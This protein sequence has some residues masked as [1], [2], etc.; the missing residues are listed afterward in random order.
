[1]LMSLF[2]SLQSIADLL[3]QAADCLEALVTITSNEPSKLSAND[4]QKKFIEERAQDWFANLHDVQMGL[5]SA[6]KNL[7]KAQVSPILHDASSKFS[8]QSTFFMG[9][10]SASRGHSLS[11]LAQDDSVKNGNLSPG[12]MKAFVDVGPKGPEISSTPSSSS[13]SLQNEAKLSLS[14]LRL[15]DAAW[16]QLAGSLQDLAAT[17]AALAQDAELSFD[18]GSESDHTIRSPNPDGSK[19]DIPLTRSQRRQIEQGA[20]ELVSARDSQDARLLTALFQKEILHQTTE[21]D[22]RESFMMRTGSRG[23]TA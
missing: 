13:R 23:V 21:T 20:Q 12:L 14:A 6:V 4:N 19:K 15:Q 9:N 1:M 22:T 5:R 10:G 16:K 3:S 11:T 8:S 18:S 2:P 7:R 17:K